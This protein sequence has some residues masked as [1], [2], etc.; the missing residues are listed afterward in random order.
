MRFA[1]KGEQFFGI[2]MKNKP[3]ILRGKEIIIADTERIVALYPYRDA[4]HSKINI[5]TKNVLLLVCGVSG[6]PIEK[7]EF[8]KEVAVKYIQRFC[9]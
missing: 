6:I 5:E 1:R 3:F 4:D 2:G 7:L 9:Q 8:A